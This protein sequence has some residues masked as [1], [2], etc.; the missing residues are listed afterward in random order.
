LP[1]HGRRGIGRALLDEV[2]REARLRGLAALELTTDTHVAWNR[3]W[4]EKIGFRVVTP[5]EQGAGLASAVADEE[6]RGFDLSR[7]VAMRREIGSPRRHL[8][9]SPRGQ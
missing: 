3:P 2:E 5:S 4:Y 7:R 8:D 6:R 9:G 1:E